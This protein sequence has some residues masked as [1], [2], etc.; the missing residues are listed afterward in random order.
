MK[1]PMIDFIAELAIRLFS[2]KPKFFAVIQWISTILGT[3]AAA[4]MYLHTEGVALPEWTSKISEVNVIVGSVVALIV[5][6][7]PN[8]NPEE[9][10]K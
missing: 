10:T 3:A 2:S 1:N 6:Q 4:L 8:K 5:A 9:A 7:L